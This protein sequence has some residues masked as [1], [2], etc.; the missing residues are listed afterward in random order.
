MDPQTVVKLLQAT[1]GEDNGL[2]KRAELELNKMKSMHGFCVCLIQIICS[3]AL[4]SEVRTSSALF[5]KNQTQARHAISSDSSKAHWTLLSQSERQ[6]IKTQIWQAVLTSDNTLRKIMTETVSNIAF[7]EFPDKWPEMAT[8]LHQYIQSQKS[9][10]MVPALECLV[11][12]AKKFQFR[13]KM[14]NRRPVAALV[15]VFV[16]SLASLLNRLVS[17]NTLL[18][19]KMMKDILKIYRNLTK[20]TNAVEI[21]VDQR[22]LTPWFQL[23]QQIIDKKLPEASE[24]IEPRGQPTDPEERKNWPWWKLKKWALRVCSHTFMSAMI[25]KTNATQKM[26]A[27]SKS[28]QLLAQVFVVHIAP[29]LLNSVLGVLAKRTQHLYCPDK[30]LEEALRFLQPAME[31]GNVYLKL[32]P[33]MP[34]IIFKVLFQLLCFSHHAWK[35]WKESPEDF[36]S[37]EFSMSDDYTDIQ[38]SAFHLL[39]DAVQIRPNLYEMTLKGVVDGWK[40]LTATPQSVTRTF[41]EFGLLKIFGALHRKNSDV[42][43]PRI[44]N[45]VEQILVQCVQPQLRNAQAPFMRRH[46]CETV[47]RHAAFQFSHAHH[48][49][50]SIQGILLNIRSTSNLELPVRVEAACS[51]QRFLDQEVCQ[52]VLQPILPD[53]LK[54]LFTMMDI[55]PIDEVVTTLESIILN[56]G[57]HLKPLCAQL[58]KKLVEVFFSYQTKSATTNDDAD[59]AALAAYACVECIS[60]LFQKM[61]AHSAVYPT[62]ENLVMPLLHKIFSV[63][64]LQIEFLEQGLNIMSWI[65]ICGPSVSPTM[66]ALFPKVYHAFQFWAQVSNNTLTRI[67]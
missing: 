42:S 66:W 12:V 4:P 11:R 54:A 8:I 21:E 44:R 30:V 40:K 14:P 16:P 18:A 51:L 49:Q 24:G 37:D 34:V 23:V 57:E 36:V 35:T 19:A 65:I 3:Q 15:K 33:H 53:V 67:Y 50:V 31:A 61:E 20:S 26:N 55:T 1:F 52:Q 32:K 17:Q 62:L 28:G 27:P 63:D 59:S 48:L 46:A 43:D 45:I 25:A 7:H 29:S 56:F 6:A 58:T 5:L 22:F 2:R 10:M 39:S 9:E 60:T 38:E 41:Q 13:F 64:G 47:A